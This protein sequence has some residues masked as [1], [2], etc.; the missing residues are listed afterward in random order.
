M[1]E[2][3]VK[4]NYEVLKEKLENGHL[5]NIMNYATDEVL[6]YNL[7][8]VSLNKSKVKFQ[9]QNGNMVEHSLENITEIV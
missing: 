2:E 6:F 8:V 3:I 7:K 9:L 4:K 1:F 5:C